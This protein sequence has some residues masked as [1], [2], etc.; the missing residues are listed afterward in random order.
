[1]REVARRIKKFR[2]MSAKKLAAHLRRRAV[3]MVVGPG[4]LEYIVD[5]HHHVR[6]CW[7]A[8]FRD[9]FVDQKADHSSLSE[10]EFWEIM[11]KS[12]WTHPYD[13]FGGGPHNPERL[14]ENIRGVADDPYRSLAWAVR[15]EGGY[16][17]TSLDY[18]EFKWAD[19]FRENIPI[20]HGDASY[21]RAVKDALRLCRSG[22]GRRL[23]GFEGKRP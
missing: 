16:E 19:Y 17:K 13:Q 15:R 2:K 20:I 9:I 7:E 12:A 11:R 21:K 10:P 4:Q 23:P 14:P 1:M 22:K 5:G 8:G 3:P 6:A 18:A